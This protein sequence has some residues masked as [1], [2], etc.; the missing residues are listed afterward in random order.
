[1]ICCRIMYNIAITRRVSHRN[2]LK[3]FT[4]D[5]TMPRNYYSYFFWKQRSFSLCHFSERKRPS[6][7]PNYYR[8]ILSIRSSFMTEGK[9][10]AN[11]QQ[12]Q[13][14]IIRCSGGWIPHKN[15]EWRLPAIIK[16]T[17]SAVVSCCTEMLY[18]SPL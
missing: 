9:L 4:R 8:L 17:I 10:N 6:K 3:Q 16:Q 13:L 1:M 15:I 5:I 18:F 11:N 14:T 12:C 2:C 7:R